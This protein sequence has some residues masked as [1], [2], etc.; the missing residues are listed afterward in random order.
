LGPGSLFAVRR[1]VH[2]VLSQND[3]PA[4]LFLLP[5][6]S[7]LVLVAL[8][9]APRVDVDAKSRQKVVTSLHQTIPVLQ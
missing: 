5:T 6:S 3:D 1:S 8:D 2:A 9:I 7:K 4:L